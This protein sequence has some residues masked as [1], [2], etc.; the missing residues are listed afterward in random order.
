MVE[1]EGGMNLVS[2]AA[3]YQHLSTKTRRKPKSR[4][5]K[6]KTGN[7]G[8]RTILRPR[9][10]DRATPTTGQPWWWLPQVLLPLPEHCVLY[11]FWSACFACVGLFWASFAI[12]F[13]L[14]GPQKIF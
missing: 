4:E 10:H 14:L 3:K 6:P 1:V 7:R 5:E 2:Y 12:F 13:D 9:Q 8:G 11:L